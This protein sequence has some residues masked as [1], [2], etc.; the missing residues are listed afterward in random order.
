MRSF[1]CLINR[2]SR[3]FRL[4]RSEQLEQ[5][6]LSGQ[7]YLYILRVCETPGISQ[8]G[9]AELLS[10]NKS[11]VTRQLCQL[12]KGGFVT[13]VTPENDRRSLQVFPTERAQALYPRIRAL[14][15]SWNEQLLQDL[16]EAERADL[17]EKME[18]ISQRA[19]ALLAESRGAGREEADR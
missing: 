18:R 19:E 1:L 5:E 7:Q 14:H 12:E 10:I 8:D 4:Y 13:R 11:N 9:L 3:F 6:G 16:T 2:T 17:C 15:Q